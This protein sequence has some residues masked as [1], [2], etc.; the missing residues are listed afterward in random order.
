MPDVNMPIQRRTMVIAG[1]LHMACPRL[2][3]AFPCAESAMGP[4]IIGLEHE[5]PI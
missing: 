2:D 1:L 5:W 3:H 4:D